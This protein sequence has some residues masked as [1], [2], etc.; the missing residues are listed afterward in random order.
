MNELELPSGAGE[1]IPMSEFT[2]LT[3]AAIAPS[4]R[5]RPRG[6]VQYADTP[7]AYAPVDDDGAID[8]PIELPIA[9]SDQLVIDQPVIDIEGTTISITEQP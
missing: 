9:A 1:L 6:Y 7:S 3:K 2:N 8:P 5:K 4:R